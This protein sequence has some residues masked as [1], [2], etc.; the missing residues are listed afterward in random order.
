MSRQ[1]M[2]DYLGID[3]EQWKKD[4]EYARDDSTESGADIF[5][6]LLNGN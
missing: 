4:E 1:Q 5:S 2:Q 6:G 3:H